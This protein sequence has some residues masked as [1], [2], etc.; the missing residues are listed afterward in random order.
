VYSSAYVDSIRNKPLDVQKM[1]R[2]A[3]RKEAKEISKKGM[4]EDK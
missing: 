2:A 4:Q 1:I 3:N